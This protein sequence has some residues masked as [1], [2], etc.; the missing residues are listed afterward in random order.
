[1]G[2]AR[3]E[4]GYLELPRLVRALGPDGLSPRRVVFR[5]QSNFNIPG[6]EPGIAAARAELEACPPDQVEVIPQP[7]D[8]AAYRQL[9]QTGDISLVL[10]D[11]TVYY[12]RSS[13]VLVE[14]LSAGMPVLTVA[15]GWPAAQFARAAR[16]YQIDLRR[17]AT[18]LAHHGSVEGEADS[19]ALR[20]A[21]P[22]GCWRTQRAV[23]AGS[24]AVFIGVRAARG[25]P[26]EHAKLR[27]ELDDAHGRPRAVRHAL[28]GPLADT[29]RLVAVLPVESE[30]RLAR[31]SVWNAFADRAIEVAA[32]SLEFVRWE[33]VSGDG[34]PRSVA[35][36]ACAD[37][38]DLPELLRELIEHYAHYQRT[39][40]QLADELLRWHNPDRLVGELVGQGRGADGSG[41]RDGGLVRRSAPAFA[42]KP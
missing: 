2:D 18:V 31:L 13:G 25:Q 28:I 32:W 10:Y 27:F 8:A 1:L 11:P 24:Q 6:G 38:A 35:G 22:A 37:P 5:I 23:P 20:T 34:F 16:E 14:S 30:A 26:G 29:E 15:G 36:L 41:A 9:V 7:L 39:A 21:G 33:G 17:K 42:R 4:K 40:A 12:A 19:A 3:T